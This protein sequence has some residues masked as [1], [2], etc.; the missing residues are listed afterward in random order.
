MQN[1]HIRDSDIRMDYAFPREPGLFHSG[2][3]AGGGGSE[4][5]VP[6][7]RTVATANRESVWQDRGALFLSEEHRRGVEQGKY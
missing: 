4:V 3:L 6:S 7:I 2:V 1:V 5:R